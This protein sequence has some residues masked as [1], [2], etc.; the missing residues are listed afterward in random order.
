MNVTSPGIFK[1]E[2][3]VS[4]HATPACRAPP[5]HPMHPPKLTAP[6]ISTPMAG[7]N[8]HCHSENQVSNRRCKRVGVGWGG[9][10]PG[11]GRVLRSRQAAKQ[12]CLPASFCSRQSQSLIG[13]WAACS[14]FQQATD[15]EA[16]GQRLRHFHIQCSG[17]SLTVDCSTERSASAAPSQARAKR[18][19]KKS[20]I[21]ACKESI[22]EHGASVCNLAC[23]GHAAGA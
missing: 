19:K 10:G 8:T 13:L 9:G 2:N 18:M 7:W 16:A 11:D 22:G 6:S 21:R 14:V 3:H 12:G 17:H 15:Q 23:G 20:A 4:R 1:P 5:C